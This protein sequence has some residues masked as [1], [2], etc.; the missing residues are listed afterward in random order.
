MSA[1]TVFEG[2]R[3]TLSEGQLATT[4]FYCHPCPTVGLGPVQSSDFWT[5]KMRGEHE[6]GNGAR[7]HRRLVETP[8]D[9]VNTPL[10]ERE[11]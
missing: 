2:R 4:A 5:A 10:E 11:I 9:R 3:L 6:G 1:L 7:K 8:F